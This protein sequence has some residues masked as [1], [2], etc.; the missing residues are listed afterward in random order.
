MLQELY[1]V[2]Y[3]ALLRCQP[4]CAARVKDFNVVALII[5]YK[6]IRLKVYS[7]DYE[8]SRWIAQIQG[9]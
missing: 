9:E 6:I 4:Y 5:W 7:R 2:K 1:K 3:G 8:D